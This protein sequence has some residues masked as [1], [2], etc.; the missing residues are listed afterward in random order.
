MSKISLSSDSLTALQ[1]FAANIEQPQSLN[2]TQ[3]AYDQAFCAWCKENT[4]F[5]CSLVSFNSSEKPSAKV[6]RRPFIAERENGKELSEIVTAS[7]ERLSMFGTAVLT[8]P[9]YGKQVTCKLSAA[10]AAAIFG[11]DKA[12]LRATVGKITIGGRSGEMWVSFNSPEIPAWDKFIAAATNT[13][14]DPTNVKTSK[15]SKQ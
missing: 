14:S 6:E 5:E 12:M 8:V 3:Y 11:K 2:G 4:S 1:R 10:T 15:K 9:E 13:V 7:P